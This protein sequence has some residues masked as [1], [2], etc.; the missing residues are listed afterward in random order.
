MALSMVLSFPITIWPMREDIIEMLA[1][2]LGSSTQLSPAAYYL[3]TYASLLA[4]YLV[5]VVIQS[6]YSV[7]WLLCRGWA[8][9]CVWGRSCCAAPVHVQNGAAEWRHGRPSTSTQQPT[10]R[11]TPPHP[12]PLL[13]AALLSRWWAL[14][15]PR[16]GPQWASSFL[17]CWHFETQ[18]VERHTRPLAGG[19]WRQA[20]CCLQSASPPLDTAP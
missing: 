8:G 17:E 10:A 13:A 2:S 3:L 5:A 4:I 1:H 9:F 15:A 20:P 7:G 6:A 18:R 12:P 11:S 14:W 19:C 16:V